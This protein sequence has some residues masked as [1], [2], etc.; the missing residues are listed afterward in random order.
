M[1]WSKDDWQE[2]NMSLA[3]QFHR[4]AFLAIPD[5]ISGDGGLEGFSKDDLAV[6]YQC[7]VPEE[8][9]R[10]PIEDRIIDKMNKDTLKLK[11]NAQFFTKC[12]DAIRLK[13]WTLLIPREFMQHKSIAEHAG[14]RA[15]EVRSWNLPFI[16]GS[17]GITISCGSEFDAYRKACLEFGRSRIKIDLPTPT[18]EERREW[19]R[20]NAV[21]MKVL[22]DKLN[23]T[24][25]KPAVVQA[26]KDSLI[27]NAVKAQ[28]SFAR[29]ENEDPDGWSTLVKVKAEKRD[30][31]ELESA[32][33]TSVPTEYLKSV[34]AS[35]KARALQEMP[36]LD[37]QAA[38]IL[39]NEA[40]V[41]WLFACPLNFEATASDGN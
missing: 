20:S 35:Y 10:R 27:K 19:E 38:D 37:D 30:A 32:L 24:H 29:L 3:A 25:S 15:R 28:N 2:L 6:G 23:Q 11:N 21:R 17:F 33:N 13:R 7:Y 22:D 36:A 31:L 12:L 39:A 41:E 16:D 4:G 26:V 18:V 9:A 34:I 40:I 8:V 1:A 5:A 14:V